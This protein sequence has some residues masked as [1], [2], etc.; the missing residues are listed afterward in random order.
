MAI[1]AVVSVSLAA[2][3]PN[4][5][6]ILTED[7]GAHL[8][9]LNTAEL[10][11]PHIDGLAKSGVYFDNAFVAY[12][13]C[14]ASKAALYTGLHGHTNG[15]LNNTHNFHKPASKVT[16]AE[17]NQR[18]AKVNRVRDQFRT[19]PEILKANGYYQ[20]VTHK[21]HVL[22][23]RKFP[24]DEFLHGDQG[25]IRG[26]I[27]RATSADKPWFL[28][29]NIPNSHRPYPN[30]DKESIRVDPAKVKLPAYL[31]DTALVRKDWAEYLAG[32]EEADLLT[33]EALDALRQSGADDNTIVIFMSDHGPT[34]PH[35]KMTLHDL[36]LRVPLAIRGPGIRA[37]IRSAD[38]VTELDLL[39]TLLQLINNS[40]QTPLSQT[41]FPYSLHGKSL[42]AGLVDDKKVGH[43]F[44]FAEISNRGPV[45][46]DGIQERS[47]FDGRWKLIYRENVE[48]RW[49]QVNADSRMFKTWGNRSYAE[50][51]RV[52]DQFPEAFRILSEQDPQQLGGDVPSLEFYDLQNDPDEMQNLA[53]APGVGVHQARLMSALS[54]WVQ[55]TKDTSIKNL[56]VAKVA[57][58]QT[59]K[60]FPVATSKKGLQVEIPADAIALGVKHA[61]FNFNLSAM[62]ATTPSPSNPTWV[63]N[64]R[65]YSF[66]QGY[67]ARRDAEIKQLSDSGALVYLVV[68]VYESQKHD[69]LLHPDYA[70]DAPNRISAFNTVT[71][72]GREA[73]SAAME[74]MAD[75]WSGSKTANGR[76]VGYIM[77]NEVNSHWWWSNCGEKTMAQFVHDY[78]DAI[79]LAEKAV[80]TASDWARVYV[81][82]DHHWTI[83]H[84]KQ[85][86]RRSFFGKDFLESFAAAAKQQGD[87]EWHLAFH[88]YPE[89]LFDARFWEDETAL[90]TLDSPR[91]TFNN[92][93]VLTDFMKQPAMRL[94]GEPRSIILSEQGFHTKRGAEGERLQAAAYCYAYRKVAM[95]QDIDAFILHR[96]V[97][98]PK[99]GGLN[100]GLRK[101]NPANRA[102]GSKKIIYNV[103]RDA[104][105]ENWRQSFEFALPI[106]G[107]EDWP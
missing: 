2:D 93:S 51:L 15:I 39:P 34:F 46:N 31:P 8:S 65:K 28:M 18:L 27:D 68:L 16:P 61:V 99:E 29:V 70:A 57:A 101:Y 74:F 59:T 52:K 103:F 83:R 63:R 44:V 106:V 19:L 97:D 105:R 17:R 45:P 86:P 79:S 47:V 32:I 64:G 54:E 60:S 48:K 92:L 85:N 84:S 22:P 7:Q 12:P 76:V 96:H 9:L 88:P 81:S 75:R 69:F 50:T 72:E 98:H 71:E 42:A 14:S 13:V 56:P 35:G 11:T 53:G 90:P 62:F 3:R 100:L 43:D 91:V 1:W 66:D 5:M 78:A 24:F 25:E 38:L 95:A 89:N 30:S 41:D 82:L 37:G 20:G 21:L 55:Q 10:K 36:G 87:P 26:F 58:R 6:F 73:L 107:L 77:G 23:N 67:L 104:D 94:H 80:R 4:V 102:S 33:G 40:T 49:R